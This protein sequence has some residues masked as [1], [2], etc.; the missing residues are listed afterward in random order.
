MY[1]KGLGE[2]YSLVLLCSGPRGPNCSS[3]SFFSPY[4][5]FNKWLFMAFLGIRETSKKVHFFPTGLGTKQNGKNEWKKTHMRVY[6]SIL[7]YSAPMLG[8]I[9]RSVDAYF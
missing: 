5:L 4:C 3:F 2:P 8:Y 1:G 6:E 7:G 9:H